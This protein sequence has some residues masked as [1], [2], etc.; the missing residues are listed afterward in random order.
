MRRMLT[1]RE[2]V[3]DIWELEN[4][5]NSYRN[6]LC[7][8]MHGQD[9]GILFDVLYDT[10]FTWVLPEDENRAASGRYLRERFE[11][12]TGLTCRDEW[13]EWPCSMLEMLVS[14]AYAMDAILYEPSRGER[15]DI[16][17]WMILDNM[18]LGHLDD[19]NM[20]SAPQS[21]YRHI[22]SVCRRVCERTYDSRG[23][24][25]MFPLE[26][27]AY[28]DQRAVEIWFQMQSYIMENFDRLSVK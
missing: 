24:G 9:Y 11:A 3:P 13:T 18:E 16:W 8:R 15:P 25:G 1:N 26:S 5:A 2:P 20:L 14:L 4:F 22:E 23:R 12:E 28:G 27:S 19:S 6:W 17:F 21:T 10:E 7:Y